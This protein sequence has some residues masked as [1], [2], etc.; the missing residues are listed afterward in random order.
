VR[1]CSR[2]KI[3]CLNSGL[4][5]A[6]LFRS[7]AFLI[8]ALFSLITYLIFRFICRRV[9]PT[10]TTRSA[11][12]C[13]HVE[14][15]GQGTV[16]ALAF[17]FFPFF[18]FFLFFF[19]PPFCVPG[20]R[21]VS[22]LRSNPDLRPVRLAR[23]QFRVAFSDFRHCT[24]AGLG[25]YPSRSGFAGAT[26]RVRHRSLV[27]LLVRP[28]SAHSACLYSKHGAPIQRRGPF[29]LHLRLGP[30]SFS[31]GRL[32]CTLWC[33]NFPAPSPLLAQQLY[34]TLVVL[35]FLFDPLS[36]TPW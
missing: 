26:S 28:I 7:S 1:P 24:R 32:F 22:S 15:C 30:L 6:A 25:V 20:S 11:L 23:R 17:F 27:S 19:F 4:S 16:R 29:A 3:A 14:L 31:I 8:Y 10:P 21:L 33:G 12:N 2:A 36:W 18:L 13:T 5:C 34:V 9:S 35:F